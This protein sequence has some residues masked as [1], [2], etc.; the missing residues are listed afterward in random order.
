VSPS[1]VARAYARTGSLVAAIETLRRGGRSLEIFD[2]RISADVDEV[3][4][5]AE[6]IDPSRPYDA[7]LIPREHRSPARRQLVMGTLGLLALV[8]LAAL[9]QWTP[10]REQLNAP[11][12]AAQL[13]AWAHGPAAALLTL[14]GFLL[15]G[16]LVMPVLLLIAVTVLAF[17]PWWGFLYAFLGMT[18]SAALTFG[19]GRAVGRSIIDRLPGTRLHH[20][21]RL[22]ASKGLLA[23]MTLRI[24]PLAPFSIINVVAG[25]SHIR[26]RDFLVGTVIG[27][28]PGLVGIALFVDQINETL[29][30][31]GP[32]SVGMLA[33]FTGLLVAVGLG[34]RRWLRAHPLD[35][36]RAPDH[37]RR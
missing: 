14:G 27:E 25:A 24:V 17:G 16:L 34:L 29:Q 32:A 11:K 1:D 33:V 4:P 5:D 8:L 7:Q 18:A 2:G 15:G 35:G 12:L 31:P 13:E 6:L 23:V 20:V 10:M 30:H 22:L 37:A 26:T 9:W 3:V 19:I 21:S 36:A 28:L